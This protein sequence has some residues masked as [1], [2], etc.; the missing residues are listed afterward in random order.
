MSLPYGSAE[1][2]LPREGKALRLRDAC[3]LQ[4]LQP[5]HTGDHAGII[6]LG[7]GGEFHCGNGLRHLS[8]HGAAADDLDRA[9]SN[10][11]KMRP[12]SYIAP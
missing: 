7:L 8:G 3:D 5:R 6:L 2:F 4:I 12:P 10:A 9:S 11:D 1:R